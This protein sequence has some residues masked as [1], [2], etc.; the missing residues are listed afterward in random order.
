MKAKKNNNVQGHIL[1]RFSNWK[2]C[3]GFQHQVSL[4]VSVD[5]FALADCFV[6]S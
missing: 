5:D 2:E 4:H 3:R 6:F 1:I